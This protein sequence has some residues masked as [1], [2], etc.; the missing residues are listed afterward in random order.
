M[1]GR[2][3]RLTDICS[4]LLI[5][6]FLMIAKIPKLLNRA[7]GQPVTRQGGLAAAS[8][9]S[10]VDNRPGPLADKTREV[11]PSYPLYLVYPAKGIWLQAIDLNIVFFIK[12][13]SRELRAAP[14]I[15]EIAEFPDSVTAAPMR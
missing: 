13:D 8:R 6:K 3:A 9:L 14:A 2:G 4:G 11:Q 12:R 5:T 1:G 10:A 7:A 15:G